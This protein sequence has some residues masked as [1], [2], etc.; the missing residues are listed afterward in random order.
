MT[1]IRTAL[2][3]FVLT[4]AFGALCAKAAV[5]T[6]LVS[7]TD[8]AAINTDMVDSPVEVEAAIK[9][10]TPPREGSKAPFRIELSDA[11]GSM[12]LVIWPDIY[13]T[14]KAQSPLSAGDVIHVSGKVTMYRDSLQLQIHE[15]TDVKTVTKAVAEKAAPSPAP[16]PAPAAEPKPTAAPA[17]LA[18]GTTPV[19]SLTPAMVGKDVTVQAAITEVREPR[20][21]SKAPFIVTLTQDNGHVALVYW[22][23]M[24]PQLKDKIKVG[25]RVRVKAQVSD[26]RG[27]L[28][29][30]IRNAADVTVVTAP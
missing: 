29:L 23:D 1:N 2:N 16:V 14:I 10:I 19:A 21:G 3:I 22:S 17:Q 7:K 9:T 20:E 18:D 4:L 12:M 13:E 24:Q 30:K 28:Q 26:Y 5:K 11:T 6:S 15:A 25:N 27:A 8:L